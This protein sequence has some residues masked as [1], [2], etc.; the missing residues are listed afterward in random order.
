MNR[1]ND[2]K[3]IAGLEKAIKQK[4]EEAPPAYLLDKIM[5]SILLDQRKIARRWLVANSFLATLILGLTIYLSPQIYSQFA[6]SNSGTALFLLWTDFGYVAT[7]WTDFSWLLLES[8]SVNAILLS[9]T[10]LL[11][12]LLLIKSIAQNLDKTRYHFKTQK[13]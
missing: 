5:T 1:I 7:N 12:L 2:I 6:H 9:L 11:S 13:I 3:V 4:G 10:G 8:L